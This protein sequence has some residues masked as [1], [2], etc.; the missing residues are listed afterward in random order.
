MDVRGVS[1]LVK[2]VLKDENDVKQ[3]MGVGGYY[4]LEPQ[5]TQATAI[6]ELTAAVASAVENVVGGGPEV[7]ELKRKFSEVQKSLDDIVAKNATHTSIL[8]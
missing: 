2:H 3:W 1:K 5:R 6:P 4:G 8:Q 7:E